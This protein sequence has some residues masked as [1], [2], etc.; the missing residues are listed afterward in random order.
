MN[1]SILNGLT[2][3]FVN[4]RI[5]SN[6]T[7]DISVNILATGGSYAGVGMQIFAQTAG[8]LSIYCHNQC[9]EMEIFCPLESQHATFDIGNVH[10]GQCVINCGSEESN[11]VLCGDSI[12]WADDG[13]NNDLRYPIHNIHSH[14]T[15]K[16]KCEKNNCFWCFWCFWCFFFLFFFM[17][18]LMARWDQ[19]ME[20]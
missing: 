11:D 1:V 7:Q 5:I 8:N 3:T 6:D 9:N 2:D 14:C 4:G 16:Q 12:I 20:F 18:D 15:N 19:Q 10:N 13:F 17:C